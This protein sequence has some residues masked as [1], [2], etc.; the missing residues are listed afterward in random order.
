[1]PWLSWTRIS[2]RNSAAPSPTLVSLPS[3]P[4]PLLNSSTSAPVTTAE[5]RFGIEIAQPERVD[6]LQRWL[7][8]DVLPMFDGRILEI[9]EDILFRWRLLVEDGRKVGRTFSQP[10]L[11]LAAVALEYSLV[12]VTRNVK[13][14]TGL[15]VS[16]HNP[17]DN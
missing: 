16:L 10:D 4:N 5:I 11:F 13:D 17:W 9:T 15:K 7:K 14:F 1:M 2:S 6:G 8:T 12:L 3:S